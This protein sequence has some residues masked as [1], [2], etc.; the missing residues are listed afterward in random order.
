MAK[1]K[2]RPHC[3]RRVTF[4]EHGPPDPTQRCIL[5]VLSSFLTENNN[6]IFPSQATIAAR[7]GCT[8]KTVRTHLDALERLG[9]NTRT[10][11]YQRGQGGQGGKA[12]EYDLHV[13]GNNADALAQFNECVQEIEESR[14]AALEQV[15]SD[16]I[17]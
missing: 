5:Y 7:A 12:H 8:E 13:P 10:P 14:A 3:F 17:R 15:M 6:R 11:R 2:P 4:S 1:F 9:W 16:S